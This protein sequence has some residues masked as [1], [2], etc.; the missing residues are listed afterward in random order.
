MKKLHKKVLSILLTLCMIIGIMPLTAF[1]QESYT[2]WTIEY[3][4]QKNSAVLGT[5]GVYTPKTSFATKLNGYTGA[6]DVPFST[7][8]SNSISGEISIPAGYE[9]ITSKAITLNPKSFDGEPRYG[10]IQVQVQPQTV[11][12]QISVTC[13][14]GGTVTGGGN[15]EEGQKVT[16]EARPDLGYHF[17]HWE[18]DSLPVSEAATYS[19]NASA[20]RSL[21]AVFERCNWLEWT[22]NG[23]S[24]HSRQCSDC[25]AIEIK[26]CGGGTGD[27]LNKPICSICHTEYADLGAHD[28]GELIPEVPATY[29]TPGV[30]AHY[31]CQKCNALFDQ[32]Q[33]PATQET[34]RIARTPKTEWKLVFWDVRHDV[35]VPSAYK[36]ITISDKLAN[37][38]ATKDNLWSGETAYDIASWS[39]VGYN[40][41]MMPEDYQL[42]TKSGSVPTKAPTVSKECVTIWIQKITCTVTTSPSISEGGTTTG[43]GTYEIKSDVIVSATPNADYH[44]VN[45]VTEDGVVESTEANYTF[46]I[47][48]NTNLTAVFEPCFGGSA[49]YFRKAV[50]TECGNEYGSLLIDT[51]APTGEITIDTNKWSQFLNK[52][53]FDLFFKETKQVKITAEDDSYAV[54]GYT[55]DKAA[56]IAYYLSH[57]EMR[58]DEIKAITDWTE[59]Q[60]SF[61]ISSDNEYVI[62]AKITDHAGNNTYISSDGLVLDSTAPMISGIENNGI[63][64]GDTTFK[65]SDKY[66]ITTLVDGKKIMLTPDGAYTIP[67]DNEPHTITVTDKAGNVT[68]Y[69]ITVYKIYTVTYVADGK[70]VSTQ[71]IGYGKDAV[72]PDIP[73]KVG[74]T[75]TVPVWDHDGMNITADTEIHAVYKINKYTVTYIADG[76][77]VD[78]QIVEHGADA[79]APQIPEK[80]GYT[81]TASSWDKDG[82]NI[83][84]DTTITAVYTKDKAPVNPSDQ[85]PQT[86]D[87]SNRLLWLSLLITSSIAVISSFIYIGYNRR[88]RKEK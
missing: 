59:Y 88:R 71:K 6:V 79:K 81:K 20:E 9:P 74:Y 36:T 70:T 76:K 57:R 72:V 30:K 51:T 66:V 65:A 62:Y 2:S 53:T 75:Q 37:N 17:L 67:A 87:T 28:F 19:F 84:S 38:L 21:N 61:S 52:I 35:Q 82:K 58:L 5:T 42:A 14:E 4:D 11:S 46:K 44:F 7:M 86:G 15:Y 1:A 10:Y 23:D 22:S 49:S 16:V 50:C 55:E 48:G 18:E 41:T 39:D 54:N 8:K 56:T 45:W 64:Y 85:S 33:R 68:E 27:C 83:T 13:N 63:Y 77:T 31:Q 34:L 60:D 78:T 26:S 29:E 24:T 3:Y 25:S 80:P 47:L 73:E 40:N 32:N 12:Y 69:T 43:D